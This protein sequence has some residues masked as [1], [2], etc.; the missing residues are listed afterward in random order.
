MK[1]YPTAK[2]FHTRTTDK[3]HDLSKKY[4]VNK[5]NILILDSNVHNTLGQEWENKL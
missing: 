2:H 4:H 3:E 5:P 1:Q